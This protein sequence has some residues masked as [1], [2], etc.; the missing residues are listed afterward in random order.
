V[1]AKY[2]R[3]MV[4]D[5]GI[6][7]DGRGLKDIRPIDIEF[8]LLP[9]THG[10]CL[11]TRGETQALV[12]CTLGGESM[13]Q[14]YEDLNG[15]GLSRFYLQYVFPPFSVGEVGRVGAPG[16]REVGHGKLAE[17]ALLACV[18]SL[19]EFPYTI[20]L[21]STITESNGSSSM[22]SVCGGCL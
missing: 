4:L 10:D 21:E 6:R 17:R 14:R 15:E 20:R 1:S 12:V 22:A 5:K 7:A 9:R 11:F 2:M 13:G 16:R 8:G 3:R 18:P 19:E